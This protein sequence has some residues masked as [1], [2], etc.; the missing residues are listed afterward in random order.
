MRWFDLAG[1]TG[2]VAGQAHREIADPH[3]LK[4]AE[5]GVQVEV[6]SRGRVR[7]IDLN[8]VRGPWNGGGFEARLH[9]G[10]LR[11]RR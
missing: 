9:G 8:D 5:E 11:L 4:G 1:E 7:S 2:L 3:G 10:G 6:R